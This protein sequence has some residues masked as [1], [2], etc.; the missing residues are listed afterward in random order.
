[1]IYYIAVVQSLLGP[2]D[3]DGVHL[4]ILILMMLYGIYVDLNIY[5]VSNV[6]YVSCL[7]GME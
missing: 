1:M 2:W 4:Y 6:V 3:Q 7:Q 5:T